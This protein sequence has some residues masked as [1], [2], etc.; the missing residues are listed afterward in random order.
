MSNDDLNNALNAIIFI[1]VMF[2]HPCCREEEELFHLLCAVRY[3]LAKL[4]SQRMEEST[5]KI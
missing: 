2:R 4:H 5:N 1:H 3:R